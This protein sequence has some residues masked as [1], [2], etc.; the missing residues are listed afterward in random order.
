MSVRGAAR[1]VLLL[2]LLSACGGRAV[3]APNPRIAE[4]DL[5]TQMLGVIPPTLEEQ[6]AEGER[7]FVTACAGCHGV[8]GRG[9][10]GPPIAGLEGLDWAPR[11][12][13]GRRTTFRSA[14]D[15]VHWIARH[16]PADR[17]GTLSEGAYYNVAAYLLALNRVPIARG[18]VNEHTAHTITLAPQTYAAPRAEIPP[19]R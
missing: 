15:L 18:P 12:E 7:V 5:G 11:P 16:M 13:S 4:P 14:A 19:R 2:V 17:P 10:A 3:P 9:G 8:D 6:L 1:S